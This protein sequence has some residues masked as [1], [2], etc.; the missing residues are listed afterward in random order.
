MTLNQWLERKRRRALTAWAGRFRALP[1]PPGPLGCLRIGLFCDFEGHFAGRDADRYADRGTDRLVSML[2]R[3]GLEIT[4]NVVADLCRSHPDRVRRVAAAGHEIACHGWK[5]ERPRGLDAPGTD[6][7]LSQAAACFGDLGLSPIGFRSPESAWSVPLVRRLARFGYRWNAEGE[8]VSRRYRIASDLVRLP[9][10]TD[11]WDL[12]DGSGR[13]ADVIAK[14]R[15][16]AEA[17]L[18]DGSGLLCLGVHEW[19]IGCDDAFADG[20][21][22]LLDEW[23]TRRNVRLCTLRELAEA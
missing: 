7:V 20:L 14:W 18:A 21:A 17:G 8:R 12:A 16:F 1:M 10:R 4:F 11:D 5:H 13:A 23:Q 19:I 22:A 3:C 2:A 15:R 9:I 6:R